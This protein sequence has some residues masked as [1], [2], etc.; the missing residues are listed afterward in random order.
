MQDFSG[1]ASRDEA[2]GWGL[3]IGKDVRTRA[4]YYLGNHPFEAPHEARLAELVNCTPTGLRRATASLVRQN[5]IFRERNRGIVQYRINELNPGAKW[6]IDFI[7]DMKR[8]R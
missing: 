2:N 4:L 1:S 3:L 7:D 8:R 5:I 6:I